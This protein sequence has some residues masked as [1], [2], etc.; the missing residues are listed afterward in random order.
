MLPG[1]LCSSNRPVISDQRMKFW[2]LGCCC[3]RFSA[4]HIR[5]LN[6]VTRRVGLSRQLNQC[7][8]WIH[9][10]SNIRH[11]PCTGQLASCCFFS[12][13][14]FNR[15]YTAKDLFRVYSVL[16]ANTFFLPRMKLVLNILWTCNENDACN[17]EVVS[18]G[19]KSDAPHSVQI[20]MFSCFV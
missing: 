15:A 18:Q 7:F 20:H 11:I 9:Q 4:F 10:T 17:S 1:K 2:C 5:K 19:Q 14:H 16:L 8:S 13:S 6:D 12:R 3:N